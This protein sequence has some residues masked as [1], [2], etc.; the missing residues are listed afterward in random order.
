MPRFIPAAIAAALVLSIHGGAQAQQ[1]PNQ[2]LAS[3]TVKPYY[4]YPPARGYRTFED[5]Q[6]AALDPANAYCPRQE[7]V[8]EAYVTWGNPMF[9]SVCRERYNECTQTHVFRWTTG[10]GD[11]HAQ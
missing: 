7:D 10:W 5:F 9:I 4:W 1:V 11:V 2:Q 3:T 8:C 6:R